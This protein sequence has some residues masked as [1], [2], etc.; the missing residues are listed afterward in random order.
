VPYLPNASRGIGEAR[1]QIVVNN[2]CTM[3]E[4]ATVTIL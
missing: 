3:H 4:A 1:S 2:A